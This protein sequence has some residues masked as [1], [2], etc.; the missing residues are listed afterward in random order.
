MSDYSTG[1]EA[2]LNAG[3]P[4]YDPTREYIER[5]QQRRQQQ[6]INNAFAQQS[7]QYQNLLQRFNDLVDDYNNLVERFNLRGEQI[8]HAEN[9]LTHSENATNIMEK[10]FR[11]QLAAHSMLAN[12]P[13]LA[14]TKED[15]DGFG[16]EL[17]GYIADLRAL[18]DGEQEYQNLID[19][20]E[21][22]GR[23]IADESVLAP[24]FQ[25]ESDFLRVSTQMR[26]P[27]AWILK[28]AENRQYFRDRA[29]NPMPISWPD[30]QEKL[31]KLMDTAKQVTEATLE[32]RFIYQF[33]QALMN[34]LFRAI[35]GH[36]AQGKDCTEP[37]P[38][39]AAIG[40]A[41]HSD[42]F[43]FFPEKR[44]VHFGSTLREII[45]DQNG[46][47][48][49]TYENWLR[50]NIASVLNG[51]DELYL[52]RKGHSADPQ[53]LVPH[54]ANLDPQTVKSGPAWGASA[55]TPSQQER[56]HSWG[57]NPSTHPSPE[58]AKKSP[59]PPAGEQPSRQSWGGPSPS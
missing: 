30:R 2:G 38:V 1:Y 52:L 53:S 29:A 42:V 22:A 24:Y 35:F 14:T 40:E 27:Q 28:C 16:N 45:L 9:A 49:G 54:A 19:Y 51:M 46:N 39:T 23:S 7:N 34:R 43:P 58:P 10:G 21:K 44:R 5:L 57:Q 59:E 26:D 25:N 4:A 50:Q 36:M 12:L 8:T 17:R 18:P 41:L 20:M 32:R 56:G 6:A 37:E 13:A 3:R 33:Y 47:S 15:T 55:K 31:L 11:F 48:L